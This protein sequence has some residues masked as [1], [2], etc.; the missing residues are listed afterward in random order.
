MMNKYKHNLIDLDVNKLFVECKI[1]EIVEI[2][3]LLDAEIERKRTELRSM[4]GDRYK[5]IL[6]ASDSIKNMKS[7]SVQIV[8]S[9]QNISASCNTLLKKVESTNDNESVEPDESKINER[10]LVVQVRLA[11]YINEAI[12]MCL[13]KE[14]YLNAAQLYL[15]GQNIHTGVNFL[16]SFHIAK[17]PLLK[18]VQL[19]LASLKQIILER[20]IKKLESVELTAEQTCSNLNGLM[21]LQN[22]NTT[23]LI[24]IFMDHRKT[25]LSTVINSP[26][27]SVRFQISAMVKCLITTIHLLYD[28]FMDCDGLK[29]GL[30][31]KQLEEILSD[32]S[33]PTL[34]KLKLPISPLDA[35]I[36]QII[37][38]FRPK[39]KIPSQDE[40]TYSKDKL[41]E[42]WLEDTK[43]TVKQGLCKSLELVTNI[44]GLY[45]IREEALKVETPSNWESICESVKLPKNFDV[46][47]FFFQSLIT[48]RTEVLIASKIRNNMELL[49]ID[50]EDSL[51]NILKSNQN[52]IDLRKYIWTEDMKDIS[53]IN[54]HPHVGLSMKAMGFSQ[55]IVVLCEKLDHRFRELL[56]D[57][58]QYLYGIEFDS[59]VVNVPTWIRNNAPLK[60]KF[61]DVDILHKCVMKEC[62]AVNSE[63]ITVLKS[64]LQDNISDE[65]V[66]KAIFFIRL[67]RSII[68]LCPY[69]KNAVPSI[70]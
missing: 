70:M 16:T 11:I 66:K 36:P 46:W 21:L 6:V 32:N 39:F 37:K 68:K 19:N 31:F 10:I 5:D 44:K 33:E 48:Q 47:H 34:S 61:V 9:I 38:E 41:I 67:L 2:E 8:E 15:L 58:S 50:I 24:S 4:V 43:D 23:Q 59:D 35:Y 56:N 18:H 27:G 12:W 42:R 40:Q 49:K 45:I 55:T 29:N 69:L 51:I 63:L 7:I 25:A 60:K 62:V 64:M 3:K 1:E 65:M 22:Q 30:I 57:L 54:G 20:L 26:H 28:C 13:D 52:E 17:V 14:E 53:S